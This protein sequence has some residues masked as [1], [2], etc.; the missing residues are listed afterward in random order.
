MSLFDTLLIAHLLGDWLL[1][2][3]WMAIEK[4]RNWG[5][6]WS[7]V[8][9]YHM[10]VLA[11]LLVGVAG[12]TVEVLVAVAVLALSH[13]WLDRGWPVV[14]LMKALRIVRVREPE[15]WLV[16]VVDQVLHVTLLAIATAWLTRPGGP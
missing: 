9:I 8:A 4:Q 13:A 2:T 6:M 15:R 14:G 11:V 5:A 7:H 16:M 12:R 1:Q 3:E 10:L